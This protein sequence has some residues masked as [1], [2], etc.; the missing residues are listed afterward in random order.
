MK[1]VKFLL[2]SLSA[3]L[4]SGCFTMLNWEDREPISSG[5]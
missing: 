5:N 4:L 3:I 1:L 2:L